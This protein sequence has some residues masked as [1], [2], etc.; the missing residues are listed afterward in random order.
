MCSGSV[1]SEFIHVDLPLKTSLSG[2]LSLK[3]PA[4]YEKLFRLVSQALLHKALG[5]PHS[6]S[7]P[8]VSPSQV[9]VNPSSEAVLLAV[10]RLS[11]HDLSEREVARGRYSPRVS[12]L[13]VHLGDLQIQESRSVL[14]LP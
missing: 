2:F 13:V 5:Y 1:C 4:V 7:S 3:L 10:R 9:R 11:L 14:P 12:H 6:V 8:Q